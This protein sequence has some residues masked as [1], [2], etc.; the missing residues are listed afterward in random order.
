MCGMMIN[1]STMKFSLK[2][3]II[4]IVFKQM[5]Y[6][7]SRHKASGIHTRLFSRAFIF[8]EGNTVIAYVLVDTCMIGQLV[9][10]RVI[11]ALQDIY[12]DRC[13][14]QY[15]IFWGYIIQASGRI[16]PVY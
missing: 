5:G 1:P 6:G 7:N 2:V 3:L 9:K 12:G 8:E 10:K 13:G 11:R 16:Q 4:H 14:I 15:A